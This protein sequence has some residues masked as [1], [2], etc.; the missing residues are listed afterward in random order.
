LITKE[1]TFL[2]A[3]KRRQVNEKTG[4]ATE[5]QSSQREEKPG[6]EVVGG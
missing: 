2:R 4:F 1:L 3:T 5:A 6:R